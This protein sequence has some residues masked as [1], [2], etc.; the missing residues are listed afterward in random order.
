MFLFKRKPGCGI[1]VGSVREK[2]AVSPLRSREADSRLEATKSLLDH[3]GQQLTTVCTEGAYRGF[4]D[5]HAYSSAKRDLTYGRRRSD[6][7]A[8]LLV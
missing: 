2:R 3:G 1:R 7:Y 6:E 4:E 8:S 5:I